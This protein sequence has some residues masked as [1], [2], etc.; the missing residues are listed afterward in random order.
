MELSD[1]RAAK[2]TRADFLQLRFGRGVVIEP[3][4]ARLYLERNPRS[5]YWIS[6]WI[7]H[8]EFSTG[9]TKR[10]LNRLKYRGARLVLITRE[11]EP[12]TPHERFIMDA[13]KFPQV[14]I[15]YIPNLHAKFYIAETLEGRY[16]LLGSANMYQWSRD[17]YEIGVVIEARG[18][19]EELVDRLEELVIDLRST[20][21]RN[22][23]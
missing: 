21:N 13:K 7:T 23:N 3:F 9:D 6:P 8:L 18:N 4:L 2:V 1:I 14:A 5:V 10:L 19:G 15:H 22:R 12:G 16:A 17:S 11:P 20:H